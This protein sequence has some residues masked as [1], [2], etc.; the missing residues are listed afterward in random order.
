MNAHEMTRCRV[1]IVDSNFEMPAL[2]AELFRP[3]GFDL[4]AT[5]TPDDAL[6]QA[7]AFQP[8]AVYMGMNF[9]SCNGWELA[10]SLRTVKGLQSTMLVDLLDRD[11]GWQSADGVGRCGFDYFLPKPPRM[12]D[13]V[14]ALTT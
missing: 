10:S 14:K 1:L 13:I 7:C 6:K 8:H 9:D 5:N 12:R 11:S 4:I 2:M 3:Y